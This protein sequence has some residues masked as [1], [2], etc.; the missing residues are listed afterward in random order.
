VAVETAGLWARRLVPELVSRVDLV[1]FDLKHTNADRLRSVMG[2]DCDLLLEN[3]AALL[4]TD[5]ELELRLTLVPGFNDSE[6]DLV[7]IARWLGRQ[8]RVPPVR[9]QRFHRLATAKAGNFASSYAFATTRPLPA[10]AIATASDLLLS[11][12]VSVAF[13]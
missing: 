6:A 3:L 10:D 4:A 5:V 12:S 7:A 13:E 2:R 1:L 8:A 11:Q 9:L